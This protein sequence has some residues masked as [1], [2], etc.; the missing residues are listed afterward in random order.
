MMN[1]RSY[2]K[3]MALIGLFIV[4]ATIVASIAIFS[5]NVDR[6]NTYTEVISSRLIEKGWIPDFLPKDAFNIIH[7]HDL[8]T[9]ESVTEFSYK[10][11]FT[12]NLG[13]ILKSAPSQ[14]I[15]KL[16]KEA[17]DIEWNFKNVERA[18]YFEIKSAEGNSILA[19]DEISK[20][21]LFWK[22]ISRSTGS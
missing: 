21:A 19:I 15:V 4:I 22:K 16:Q 6:F 8:D 5:P 17:S 13:N 18:K 12:K 7:Q 14:S 11:P 20:R 2:L 10:Q 1:I 3:V 9:S